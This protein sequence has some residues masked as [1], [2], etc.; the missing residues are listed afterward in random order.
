MAHVIF[1]FLFLRHVKLV[2][3]VIRT[4]QDSLELCQD[5][6]LEEYCYVVLFKNK[7]SSHH[8]L[9]L[10]CFQFFNFSYH[11]SD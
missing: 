9:L 7:I 8:C 3:H 10:V 2:F 5:A 4:L 6:C 11:L 1:V